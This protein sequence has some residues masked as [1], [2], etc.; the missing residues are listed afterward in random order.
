MTLEE[1]GTIVLADARRNDYP[2]S[3][4][5]AD[6]LADVHQRISLDEL[7][8]DGTDERQV[9]AYRVFLAHHQNPT[10]SQLCSLIIAI[11]G[12]PPEY[13]PPHFRVWHRRILSGELL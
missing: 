3:M 4:P 12:A 1:A 5:D 9:E 6:V 2:A 8:D 13:L 7:Y 11:S 10:R